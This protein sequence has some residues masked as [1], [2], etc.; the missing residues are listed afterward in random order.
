M[1]RHIHAG[2]V[3]N[4]LTTISCMWLI[5]SPWSLGFAATHTGLT[6]NIVVGS[7]VLII[8]ALLSLID[9]SLSLRLRE[10][11][12][13]LLCS[14]WLCAITII[15]DAGVSRTFWSPLAI[16]FGIAFL[17]ALQLVELL[18]IA[19]KTTLQEA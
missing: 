17:Q 2:M 13:M 10:N 7:T 1:K 8:F 11:G 4:I 18:F 9:P 14:I 3:I 12:V 16:S 6:S 19:Y 5:V 15:Y